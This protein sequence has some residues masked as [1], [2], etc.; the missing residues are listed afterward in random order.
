MRILSPYPLILFSFIISA[1]NTGRT[2]SGIED[3]SSILD[4]ADAQYVYRNLPDKTA[5]T[6]LL[7]SVDGN[8]EL[9]PVVFL[10]SDSLPVDP[11]FFSIEA[12][13]YYKFDKNLICLTGKFEVYL[14]SETDELSILSSILVDLKDGSIYNFNGHYPEGL[15]YYLGSDYVQKDAGNNYYYSFGA[16]LYKLSRSGD[17]LFSDLQYLPDGQRYST[18]YIDKLGNCFYNSEGIDTLTKVKKYTGGIIQSPGYIQ[19]LYYAGDN[20]LAFKGNDIVEVKLDDAVE[21]DPLTTFG[22]GGIE[23]F[24]YMYE[25]KDKS[26]TVFLQ[27]VFNSLNSGYYGM[28][29]FS[30]TNKA[31]QV[32]LRVDE[33]FSGVNLMVEAI[34]DNYLILSTNDKS[35]VLRADLE[36]T[37]GNSIV[38]IDIESAASLPENFDIYDLRVLDMN[39]VTFV[40]LNYL[41]EKI[42]AAEMDF[43][44][45][46]T[47]LS[48]ISGSDLRILD[49]IH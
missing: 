10:N 44:E 15:S 17:G 34:V 1:C 23:R 12:E 18:Y 48:E 49:K 2:P 16:K 21:L 46:I 13:N 22:S 28:V 35:K 14:D 47:L 43:E 36:I 45:N 40:G 39:K 37:E 9:T 20:L 33:D 19:N 42:Y 29:F 5:S 6:N 38:Y 25:S 8:A 30:G 11:S 7:K 27:D 26:Y 3:Y 41:D 4:L 31:L 32:F 24:Y